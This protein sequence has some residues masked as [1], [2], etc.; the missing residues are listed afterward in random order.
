MLYVWITFSDFYN[1]GFETNV[2]FFA[3]LSCNACIRSRYLIHVL[4]TW[5]AYAFV[6]ATFP[7]PYLDQVWRQLVDDSNGDKGR[8]DVCLFSATSDRTPVKT[9]RDVIPISNLH[10]STYSSVRLHLWKLV[11]PTLYMPDRF[12]NR[13]IAYMRVS[14]FVVTLL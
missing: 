14:N 7:P 10:S 8:F 4:M 12:F 2:G 13:L 5:G 1:P 6:D 9:G 11:M 3:L